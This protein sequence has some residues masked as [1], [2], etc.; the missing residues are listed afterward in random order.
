QEITGMS[1]I[2]AASMVGI[3]GLFNGGG[4]L[5]WATISDYIRRPNVYTTFFVIQVTAY[6]LLPNT[7]N[8]FLFQILLFAILSCYGGGFSSV[9][10]SIGDIFGPK[11]SGA[12][13]GYILP[14]WAA[15]GV[16]GPMLLSL[17]FDTT[18]SYNLTLIIFGFLFVIALA[19]SFW[20]R[21]DIKQLQEQ[22][23]KTDHGMSLEGVTTKAKI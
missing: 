21:V 2:T 19:M 1:A 16:V 17:I 14:A 15:A 23:K 13:H 5:A 3:L 11:Q 8:V 12:I 4:R 18:Q 9:P 6:F 20:I 22:K 10:A 7:T